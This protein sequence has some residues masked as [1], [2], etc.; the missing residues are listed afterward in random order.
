[1]KNKKTLSLLVPL[2]VAAMTFVAC[3]DYD[4]GVTEKQIQFD[5]NFKERFTD[6][7]P[8][9]DWNLAERSGV[10]VVTSTER[11][12]KI[13][14]E[15]NGDFNILGNYKKVLGSQKLSFDMYE[16]TQVV[17]VSDGETAMRAYVG[18]T[19][20]FD[21]HTSVAGDAQETRSHD[22]AHGLRPRDHPGRIPYRRLDHV[23]ICDDKPHRRMLSGPAAEN[24]WR[25]LRG[26]ELRQ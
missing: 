19:V 17:V 7:D 26:Q 23:W 20:N 3:S 14:A 15:Q 12:I 10:T 2:A 24:A 11:N 25:W 18:G 4:N 21:D 22:D 1:M 6:I 13:Y 16:G 5:R 9:Q 8:E